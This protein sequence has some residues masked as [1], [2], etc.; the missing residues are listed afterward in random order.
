MRF[1]LSLVLSLLLLSTAATIG[2]AD[3]FVDF[4]GDGE[5]KTAYASGTVNLSGLDWDMTEALIGTLAADWKNGVRSARMRG[6]EASSMTMLQDK[7]GGLGNLS[8]LYRRYGTDI[9][10]DWMVEYSTDQ[11]TTWIQVGDAFTPPADDVVQVFSEPVSVEGPVRVRI[12]RATEDGNATNRRLNIDDILLTDYSPGTAAAPTFAPPGGTYYNPVEVT[13]STTTPDATIYY[14]V[15]GDDPDDGSTMY[16]DPVAIVETTTLKAITY[17]PGLNPSSITTAVYTFP[18]INDVPDVATLRQGAADGTVYRLAG[19]AVLTF[20]QDFRGQKY[21]QDGTAG[22]LIDDDPR[23]I[24]TVYD[25]HDGITGITGTLL[26]FGNMLQFVP[27]Y[28]PG[29]ATSF[30]NIVEPIEIATL[31][32]F[33]SNFEMYESRLVRLMNV[34]FTTPPGS[35]F[36]NGQVYILSDGVDQTL[37]RTTFY[38]VDYI[39]TLVPEG[40]LNIV[41][42]PNS[43]AE[44]DYITARD[45]ADFMTPPVY[46]ACCFEDGSC[47]ILTDD[48]CAAGGGLWEG[49]DTEC[50]PNPCP[51]PLGACCVMDTGECLVLT[52]E[53]C[54]AM[55]G[56]EY[57]GDFLPCDPNPCPPPVPTIEGTWGNIKNQF[58]Q[59]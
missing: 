22:I 41:G 23:I 29:P 50:E 55:A 59:D 33:N 54:E 10:V 21:I 30:G 57:Y 9:Q 24:Q 43:R 13:I 7:Q 38:G 14:T 4:E 15:N 52:Q 42:L 26:V 19:E 32:E 25:R 17:A 6:Y 2:S 31:A 37:F 5:T 40:T 16:V 12:K 35:Y 11:G 51:Q 49:P 20:Q 53:D 47:M 56:T 28:D 46:G 27:I 18:A 45:L 44:G 36:Q 39:N 58:R 48:D 1:R 3:Y 34:H 8:F